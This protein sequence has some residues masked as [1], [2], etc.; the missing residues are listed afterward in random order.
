MTRRQQLSEAQIAA[1]FDPPDDQRE[2]TRHYTFSD[3]DLAMISRGR[4]DHNRLG[5]ALML[6]YLRYPGRPLRAVERPPEP[7]LAFVAEQIGVFLGSISGYLATEWNRQAHA[8]EFRDRLDAMHEMAAIG[9]AFGHQ[10]R[11]QLALHHAGPHCREM[12]QVGLVQ[13]VG[14]TAEQGDLARRLHRADVVHDSSGIAHPHP[15]QRRGQ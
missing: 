15:R 3:T 11:V 4:S 13:Q 1:L 8:A 2:L 9:E 12:L 10:C 14:T 7:L 5:R 6:C